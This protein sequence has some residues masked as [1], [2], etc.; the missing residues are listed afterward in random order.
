M[1]GSSVSESQDSWNC[2]LYAL[3]LA[4]ARALLHVGSCMAT[5]LAAA[6]ETSL[7][8]FM[9]ALSNRFPAYEHRAI[10][11]R[12]RISF[13]FAADEVWSPCFLSLPPAP[14]SRV[15]AEPRAPASIMFWWRR[16]SC[17]SSAS[18]SRDSRPDSR[19]IHSNSNPLHSESRVARCAVREVCRATRANQSDGTS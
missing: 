4:G 15:A 12:D 14:V 16:P 5:A 18:T 19:V 7:S 9:Q 2:E 6:T 13:S 8:L 11:N 10:S 1:N 3:M 17:D